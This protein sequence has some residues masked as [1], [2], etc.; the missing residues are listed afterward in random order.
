MLMA[1][2]DGIRNRIHPGEPID[3]NRYDLLPRN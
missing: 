1:G 2:L 3:N